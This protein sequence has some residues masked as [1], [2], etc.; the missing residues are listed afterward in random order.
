MS[1]LKLQGEEQVSAS[2]GCHPQVSASTGCHQRRVL[3]LAHHITAANRYTVQ[4]QV[5]ATKTGTRPACSASE[6]DAS[7]K[8]GTIPARSASGDAHS[9]PRRVPDPQAQATKPRTWCTPSSLGR[10]PPPK[11]SR[12]DSSS[13]SKVITSSRSIRFASG[14]CKEDLG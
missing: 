2:T 8:T 12:P 5:D 11:G 7:A 3:R 10:R 14:I 13:E 6:A 9:Q 4:H 1:S